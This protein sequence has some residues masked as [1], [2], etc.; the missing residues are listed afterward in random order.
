[1]KMALSNPQK[2]NDVIKKNLL[3]PLLV[4]Q[5]EVKNR[6]VLSPMCQYSSVD[7]FANDW[8]LVHLGSRALG[9]AGIVFTEATAISPEG[10]ISPYDLGIWSDEQI[11][12]LAR[13]TKFISENGSL[14]AIQIAHAGRKA[15][16]QRPIDGGASL[17]LEKGGW[18]VVAPSAVAFSEKS[19]IPKSLSQ[20]AIKEIVF[21]FQQAAKRAV[22]AGFKIIEIHAAH[23]Y[24]LHQFLSPLSNQRQD[25]YGGGLE[26]RIRLLG[27]VVQAVRLVISE[28]MALFLR[29]SATDWIEGGWDLKQSIELAKQVKQLGVDVIDVSSGGIVPYA[30]IPTK[31]NY[32]VPF[33]TNIQEEAQILTGAVGFITQIKQA[34]QIISSNAADLVFIGREFLRQP[35]FGLK[36][37][38][39]LAKQVSWPKP[40]GYAL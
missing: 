35:Y 40:Y 14:P 36:A 29:I 33:A 19:Q 4:R 13:I 9:G 28:K 32:Q 39:F 1:M 30:K 11:P 8:H 24:L 18:Q 7:G 22:A 3:T 38:Q 15:S 6:I 17:P 16:C 27:E 23:G 2:T 26:N 5:T 25:E 37:Q 10:R 20:A 34:N 31:P 21:S 12:F